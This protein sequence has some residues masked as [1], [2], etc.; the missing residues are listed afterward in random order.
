LYN[1]TSVLSDHHANIGAK[2]ADIGKIGGAI[3]FDLIILY[4]QDFQER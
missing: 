2:I 4:S 1:N 3:S